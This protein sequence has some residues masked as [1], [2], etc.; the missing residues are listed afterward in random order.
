M[1]SEQGEVVA[2]VFGERD[3]PG[4]SAAQR[5]RGA[6]GDARR[7]V[8]PTAAKAEAAPE[9]LATRRSAVV[10]DMLKLDFV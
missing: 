9:I 4:R 10:E 8:G 1:I 6:P 5:H 2:S 3:A 7:N